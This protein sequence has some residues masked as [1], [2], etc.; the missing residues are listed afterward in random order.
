MWVLVR[1][2]KRS[3]PVNSF[4]I[5]PAKL[6]FVY[7][8]L[9]VVGHVQFTKEDEEPSLE[10]LFVLLASQGKL[11]VSLSVTINVI[12]KEEEEEENTNEY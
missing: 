9:H 11:I 1:V 5:L 12:F 7:H 6:T 10:C 2:F 8:D 3:L 4:Q